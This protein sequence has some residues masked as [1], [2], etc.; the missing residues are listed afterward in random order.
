MGKMPGKALPTACWGRTLDMVRF[1]CEGDEQEVAK[2]P[3]GCSL[4][5]FSNTL[6]F[7]E[8]EQAISS[9]ELGKRASPNWAVLLELEATN[10]T[11][12]RDN[13]M[14]NAHN[15]APSTIAQH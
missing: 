6:L 11:T 2:P 5:F 15:S 4:N 12:L 13:I 8:L 7:T 3:R 9:L 14:E 10:S 1:E